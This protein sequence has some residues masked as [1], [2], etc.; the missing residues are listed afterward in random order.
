MKPLKVLHQKNVSSNSSQ[1]KFPQNSS[2]LPAA[3]K[4]T[5]NKPFDTLSK[6]LEAIETSKKRENS[7]KGKNVCQKNI[8]YIFLEYRRIQGKLP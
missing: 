5:E 3:N 2:P 6:Q 7:I 1:K 4:P 8:F